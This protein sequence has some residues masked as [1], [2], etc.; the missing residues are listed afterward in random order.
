MY[1][2]TSGHADEWT[3]RLTIDTGFDFDLFWLRVI[4]SENGA[5]FADLAVALRSAFYRHDD[6][7]M[8][9]IHPLTSIV[10]AGSFAQLNPRSNEG[11]SA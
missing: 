9:G 6:V 1:A 2:Q 3:Y 10:L 4:L 8:P 11:P 5:R 7:T